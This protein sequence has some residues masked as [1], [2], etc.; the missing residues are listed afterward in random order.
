MVFRVLEGTTV[1]ATSSKRPQL[2]AS[3]GTLA[4]YPFWG[5]GNA[6]PDAAEMSFS[7]GNQ[8]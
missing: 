7:R 4:V 1:R 2:R 5:L 6:S 8:G 3:F